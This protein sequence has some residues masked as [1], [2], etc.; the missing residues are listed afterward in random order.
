PHPSTINPQ[1]SKTDCA[2]FAHLARLSPAEYDRIRRAEAKR[3]GI[4]K[5]TLDAEVAKRRSQFANHVEAIIPQSALSSLRSPDPW[6]DPVDG[7]EVLNQVAERFALYLVLPPGAA[8]ALALW[9]PHTHA[10]AA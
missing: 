9:T 4:R 8:D 5:E 2:A 10:F 7:A 6:P 1:L 3:L